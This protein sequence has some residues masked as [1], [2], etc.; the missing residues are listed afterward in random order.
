MLKAL[1]QNVEFSYWEELHSNGKD[2]AVIHTQLLKVHVACQ[3]YAKNPDSV[4][5]VSS[6][7]LMSEA[8]KKPGKIENRCTKN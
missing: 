6:F 2:M 1:I 7:L 4:V 3:R 5:F 8:A